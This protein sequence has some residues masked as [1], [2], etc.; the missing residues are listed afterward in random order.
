M[1]FTGIKQDGGYQQ[2]VL[3][4]AAYVAPLPD[5]I[6]FADAAPLMCVG[7]TV[8]S[9]LRHAG[10]ESGDKVA[11]IGLGGLGH[12]GVLP[13]AGHGRPRGSSFNKSRL[14]LVPGISCGMQG[15][16]CIRTTHSNQNTARESGSRHARQNDSGQDAADATEAQP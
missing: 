15:A 6:D 11:V 7:L 4:R 5:G 14:A 3:A 9:G 16:T 2:F 8:F 1:Q 12:L 10:F 13:C